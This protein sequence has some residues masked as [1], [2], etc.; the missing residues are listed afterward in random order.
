MWYRID[1]AAGWELCEIPVCQNKLAHGNVSVLTQTH[2]KVFFQPRMKIGQNETERENER[3][4]DQH[5]K[6]DSKIKDR[7]FDLSML[8]SRL[9]SLQ[10]YE[11]LSL[12]LF[13]FF[14]KRWLKGLDFI[15][16]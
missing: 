3:K 16:L 12:S 6:I 10:H 13:F 7:H 5:P 4:K 9:V 1:D 15:S 14:R 2:Q 11:V 8:N